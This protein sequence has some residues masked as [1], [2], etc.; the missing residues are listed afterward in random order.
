M[1]IIK[2]N[3]MEDV[4][5]YFIVSVIVLEFVNFVIRLFATG[6]DWVNLFMPFF[7]VLAV[8]LVAAS[9]ASL[10][11]LCGLYLLI[12]IVLRLLTKIDRRVNYDGLYL[13][14]AIL[15]VSFYLL[16]CVV[17]GWI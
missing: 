6:V 5:F 9:G 3:I 16:V 7:T 17:F 10:I 2:L 11:L 4:V 8:Y 12:H 15:M 14:F 13:G 1:L